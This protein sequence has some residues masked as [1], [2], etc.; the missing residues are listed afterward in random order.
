MIIF[1][2]TRCSKSRE[3]LTILKENN[4]DVEIRDYLNVPPS[5]KEI[6]EIL[7]MLKVKP[8]DIVRK[9]ESLFLE[10]YKG[11][12]ITDAKWIEILSK[13][14]ILIERPIVIDGNKAVIG[15]PPKLVI[16]FIKKKRVSKKLA[17]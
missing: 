2:N 7:A 8:I 5:K 17:E 16:D 9:T 15:R 1:H 11:K 4:C 10:N 6:K 13:H 14:P 12:K 3:T